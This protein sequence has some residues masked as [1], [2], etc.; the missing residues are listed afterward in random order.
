MAAIGSVSEFTIGDDWEE[1]CERLEQYFIAN[2]IKDTDTEQRRRAVFLS[3]IGGKTYGLLKTLLAPQKPTDKRYEDLRKILQDHLLPQPVVIAERY[4]FWTGRQKAGQS[5]SQYLAEVRKLAEKCQ[6]GDFLNDA[7]RDMF[8]I[9]LL[10]TTVQKKLLSETQLSLDKAYN[11]AL[12]HESAV[13][14]VEEIQAS[15]KQVNK[16]N[17]HRRAAQERKVCFRCGGNHGSDVCFFQDKLCYKCGRKGHVSRMCRQASTSRAKFDKQANSERQQEEGNREEGKKPK[18]KPYKYSKKGVRKVYDDNESTS[19][20]EEEIN[21]VADKLVSELS[22]FTISSFKECSKV[23]EIKVSVKVNGTPVDMEV[24]TGASVSLMSQDMKREILPDVPMSQPHLRLKTFNGDLVPVVGKCMVKVEYEGQMKILPLYIV[25]GKGPELLGRDWLSCIKLDWQ[26]ILRVQAM[27]GQV[28]NL[29]FEKFP[30][31]FSPGLGKAKGIQA[32][33]KVKENAR[34]KFFKPRPMPYALKEGVASELKRLQELGVL[35]KIDYSDWAAPIVPVRKSSGGIRICGDYKVTINQDLEI[36]E[37]PM[38][39]VEELLQQLN[40]G[41]KF[42]KLDL[43]QAYQQIELSKNSRKYVT[44]NTHLGLYSYS[45]LPYGVSAAPAMF[46]CVMDKVLQGLNVGCYLDD[47][48]I[49]GKNEEEHLANLEA[50]LGRLEGYGF[51]LQKSKCEFMVPSVTYLGYKIDAEGIHMDPEATEAVAQAPRPETKAELQS[52]LGLVNHYRKYVPQMSTLCC[53][54]NQ[55]LQKG[56]E[57]CWSRE[58]EDAFRQIRD[59]LVSPPVLTHYDPKTPVLL[60]VDASPVGLGAILSHQT[61]QGERP[62]AY[63]SR[64]LTGAERNYSQ[65]EKE[66]L[67][68]VF[69][70]NRFHQYLYGR[71]FTLITDNKP[72]SLILGPKK[73][74]PAI[75]AARIQR[76]AIQLSAY[77]YDI[78][79]RPARCNEH[80]DA[81]SRLPLKG[82]L[83][84]I[85]QVCWTQEATA[86][87][88]AQINGLPITAKVIRRETLRDPVLSRIMNWVIHGWPTEQNWT[89]EYQPYHR[90]RNELT[91][92]EGCLLWGVRT[93]IPSKFQGTLL[94]ELHVSHPGMVRMKALARNHVWWPLID[95]DIENQVRGCRS[96]QEQ[97]PTKPAIRDNPW[98]WPSGPWQRIHVDFA[99]PFMGEMFFIIVDAYSKWPYVIRMKS[100][101]SENTIDALR[102]IF[103]QQGLPLE[104]VS[105]NG[106]QFTSAE[107]EEFMKMNGIRH[108]RSAPFHPSTNGEA[109]R[110]VRTFKTAMRARK[111]QKISVQRKLCDF[112]LTYRTTP[113]SATNRSPAELMGRALRTRLD[114][115]RPNLSQRLE[116]QRQ[117]TGLE[118][119]VE[120]GEPVLVKDYRSRKPVWAQGVVSNSLG[121]C[122]YL[123]QVGDLS[124]KRHIDQLIQI[125]K[126]WAHDQRVVTGLD[127]SSPTCMTPMLGVPV[128]EAQN[129]AVQSRSDLSGKSR[130]MDIQIPDRASVSG[131]VPVGDCM[132]TDGNVSSSPVIDVPNRRFCKTT[133]GSDNVPSRRSQR[134][135]KLPAKLADYDLEYYVE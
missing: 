68:I 75:A 56:K 109:E 26:N 10:D 97:Q 71:H 79:H 58:C 16:V 27:S 17:E 80:A 67:A 81:L 18:Q 4:R 85:K 126:P 91:V 46:Q 92:E 32:D 104:L 35:E 34:P 82:E 124:W 1:Y 14:Q 13:Q 6:F 60:A 107:F 74:I 7:L 50:V 62:I 105:D 87:N 127:G 3:V 9:G 95:Q 66:G 42:S 114:A 33:L 61:S 110:F 47:L 44:I 113:H 43:S 86:L 118:R 94:E 55:L 57:F 131:E 64:S 2:N 52:F 39:K 101:T 31:L 40:G 100:T 112:L 125:D 73:G 70:L 72:L 30:H 69:G 119:Y 93:V 98:R 12:S 54:L 99:G 116:R 130:E 29:M 111:E 28:A 20:E 53:P 129:E 102:Q 108:N 11:I 76:W 8:V 38:P 115:V 84:S 90:R 36:P 59:V 122:T 103:S 24:D 96:C 77:A 117:Q 48:I 51:K 37:H 22:V 128:P 106:P 65:I 132:A 49:T 45:R 121:P 120:V 123:I 89:Q 41:V 135:R 133:D 63:A 25:Q 23:K 83:S 15:N 134:S 88:K 5:V 78:K 19:E 21:F